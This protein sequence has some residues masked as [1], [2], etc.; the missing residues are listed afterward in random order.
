M[1]NS[2][3][4]K[5]DQLCTTLGGKKLSSDHWM[6]HC[7]AHD[8]ANPSLSAT[9]VNSKILLHFQNIKGINTTQ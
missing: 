7:P 6:L 2:I 4:Q 9:K 5:F 3:D 1:A 8:D